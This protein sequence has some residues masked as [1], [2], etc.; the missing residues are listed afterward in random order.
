M[1]N[2][3]LKASS[4]IE[5]KARDNK[6]T[7]RCVPETSKT[8][9]TDN[10]KF[11]TIEGKSNHKT[12]NNGANQIA[13]I[14]NDH[15]LGQFV[16]LPHGAAHRQ[17]GVPYI[18]FGPQKGM[19]GGAN[20]A[21]IA[22]IPPVGPNLTV[23]PF[24]PQP[25]TSLPGLAGNGPLSI[26]KNPS[27]SGINHFSQMGLG[28]AL[29]DG[30]AGIVVVEGPV[31]GNFVH[32]L[33]SRIHEGPLYEIKI[34]SAVKATVTFQFWMHAQAFMDRNHDSLIATGHSC[35]GGAYKLTLLEPF[36]WHAN[37]HQM[38]HPAR[39]RRRLTFARSKLFGASLSPVKWEREVKAIAGTGNVDFVWV[40]NSGNGKHAFPHLFSDILLTVTC[41]AT[42]VFRSTAI[43]RRVRGVFLEWKTSRPVYRNVEVTFSTDPCEKELILSTQMRLRH[44]P[45]M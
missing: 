24:G 40:F 37:L 4:E 3:F 27:M 20:W 13:I 41:P 35:F 26:G 9:E 15:D 44:G 11:L 12:G 25:K 21:A 36:I 14:E 34:I 7:V 16:N 2:V 33:T 6:K 1:I 45:R 22:A 38:N 31:S 42:A 32:F 18:Q 43:A 19:T 8:T 28:S 23:G 29:E 17:G 5:I 39:E 10:M 30:K